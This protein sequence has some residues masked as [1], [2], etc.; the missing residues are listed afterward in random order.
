MR[1]RARI[2]NRQATAIFATLRLP[3][4]EGW[5]RYG[6]RSWFTFGREQLRRPTGHAESPVYSGIYVIPCFQTK[7]NAL[8]H[9]CRWKVTHS[10]CQTLYSTYN[11]ESYRD[12]LMIDIHSHILW[13]VD[14]GPRTFEDSVAMLRVAA[15]TGTTDIVATPHANARFSFPPD[16]IAE[17]VALL[18]ESVKG[19][20]HI[21]SGCDFHL[22]YDNIRDALANPNKYT[23]G[24]KS[25]LL[26]E[27]SDVFVVRQIDEVF[28]KMLAVGIVPIITHPERNFALQQRLGDLT[29]W[30]AAGCVL[31]ITA[32]SLLGRFGS[33]SQRFTEL[34]LK[35]SLVHVVASDAH[36]CEDRPPRL[37]LAYSS[38]ADK[39]S[40]E[41]ARQ[42]FVRHPRMVLRGEPI[43]LEEPEAE[44]DQRRS[45]RWF[46]PWA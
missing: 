31:Q 24:H 26:V 32:Q 45:R 14:D 33:R 42:L 44:Q 8:L 7:Y 16:L 35:K 27:F 17:R 2:K 46:G 13:G 9:E 29:R 38:V 12:T 34:L 28:G 15:D 25:Y 41:L 18:N 6:N 21:H 22:H 20:I 37:D 40:S 5:K 30:V 1:H 36:D 39:F 43:Y 19:A 11:K 23:I 3:A 10:N 4:R